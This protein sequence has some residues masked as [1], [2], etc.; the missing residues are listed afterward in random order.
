LKNQLYTVQVWH[1]YLV[2]RVKNE[3]NSTIGRFM[4][5]RQV[6]Q[7]IY[8]ESEHDLPSI[9][10]A[11]CWLAL[12]QEAS[13]PAQRS[14][15]EDSRKRSPKSNLLSAA[16]H[17]NLIAPVTKLLAEGCH[18]TGHDYLFPPPMGL[19]ARAG[20]TQILEIFQEQLPE[21][22]ETGAYGWKWNWNWHGKV[23]PDSIIGAAIRG[24]LDILKLALYPPS[25]A[26]SNTTDILGQ[27]CG[28]IDPCSPVGCVLR[29]AAWGET[30][31]IELFDYIDSLFEKPIAGEDLVDILISTLSSGT[32]PSCGVF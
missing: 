13:C 23:S 3:T 25:R 5:I 20:N 24:D 15:V 11:L 26:T 18:P 27:P 19:A 9:I 2:Y 10:D 32:S 31:S 4:E 22:I 6:A 16:A 30:R 7:F 29:T 28:Q 8:E 14:L 17:L 1:L 12:E 21:F